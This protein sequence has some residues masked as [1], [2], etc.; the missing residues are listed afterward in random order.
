MYAK[1][2][3]VSP[4]RSKAEIEKLLTKAGATY[5]ACGWDGAAAAVSFKLSG[6]QYRMVIPLPLPPGTE[7]KHRPN[8]AG[9]YRKVSV[10]AQ[11]KA[12]D[13]ALRQ[14]W[15]AVVLIIKAKLEAVE[16]GISTI[17]DQFLADVVLPSGLRFGDWASPQFQ[18]QTNTVPQLALNG[19]RASS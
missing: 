5:F 13:Q 3:S 15:R 11:R 14:R 10:A 8:A 7:D 4:D 1:D 19:S 17:E 16:A 12:Y 2:T 9:A 6:R 18:V